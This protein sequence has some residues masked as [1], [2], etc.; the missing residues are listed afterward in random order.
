MGTV[1]LSPHLDDAVL[2]CWQILTQPGDVT[3]I[4][5]FTGVPTGREEPAWWDRYTGA[6]DSGERV[7][8]R[9]EE[10]RRALSL[11]GRIPVNLDLLD[12]QYRG[13]KPPPSLTGRLMEL[14]E[15]G[16][17]VYAPATF[18]DHADHRLVGA[19][20]LALRAQ[21]CAVF[22]YAD[23]PHANVRGWPQWVT[24]TSRTASTDRVGAFW[25][26]CL[27]GTGI[28]P[29]DLA[30]KVHDL[31]AEAY[32]RKVAAVQMYTTQVSALAEYAGRPLSDHEALG[33]EV[34]WATASPARAADRA[35]SRP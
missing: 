13:G 21:E 34:F 11:A 32:A 3:V 12:A 18:A 5:V 16:A 1:I 8:E 29:E 19:A 15:P 27:A 10:D 14:I 22:L 35:A 7:R 2:S 24:G 26:R 30:P 6:A 31:D 17:L 9:I 20:A 33:Y 28:P 4:N 25:D 23:L